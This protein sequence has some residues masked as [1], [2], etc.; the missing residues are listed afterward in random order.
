MTTKNLTILASDDDQDNLTALKAAVHDA[1]PGCILLSAQSGSKVLELARAEDPDV[2]LLNAAMS[3]MDGFAVCRGLKADE[4]LQAIPVLFMTALRTDRDSRIKA[5]EAGAEGFLFRPWEESELILQIRAMAKIK[6]ANQF[7]RVEKEE[8]A[9]LVAERTCA[10]E[11]ELAE[12]KRVGQALQQSEARFRGLAEALPDLL[13]TTDADGILTYVS[14]SIGSLLGW[15]PEEAVGRN[16]TEFLTPEEIPRIVAAFRAA[17][18]E[19]VPARNLMTTIKHKGG[20]LFSGEINGLS[21]L[22][23]RGTRGTVGVIRDVTERKRAEAKIQEQARLLDL[24]FEHSLDCIVLLDKD[25]NFIRVSEAYAKAC[26]R[27]VAEFQGLNHFELYPSS[28][29]DEFD[30][31]IRSRVVFSRSARPFTFP[32]HPEW[33]ATYWDLGMVPIRGVAGEVELILLTLKDVTERRRAE[34]DRLR[35][36]VAI[37]QAAEVVVVTDAQGT[38]QYV[39]PVFETVTGYTRAEA[40]GQNPRILKSGRQDA[41][42]YRELWD[43]L[44]AGRVWQGR[45]VNRR[46]DGSLYTEDVSISPVHDGAGRIV[47]YVAVKRDITEHL[48]DHE[49]KTRLEDHLR[50]AQKVEAIGRLAGGVAHDFNNLTAIVLG[51][52]EMLVGHL[53]H[54]DPARKWAE[55]I[56]EAGRRSAALTRQLLAFSRKQTLQPEVLDLNALVKNLEKMLGRLIGEDIELRFA[57]AADLGRVMA[58]PGQ[59]EQ[60]VTN[61][62]VNARDAMPGGGMLTIETTDVV[63][64]DTYALGHESVVPGN[65]VMLALTDTGSGLDKATMARLFEPFYT[66][67]EKGKGTGL[68][69]AMVYGIVKQSGGYIYAYSEPG[70]G[71]AFKI[72]LPRTDAQPDVK[73]AE[74]VGEPL[75]GSGEQILL[76]EDE[77]P[78]REL[79]QT[80]LSR[81]GYRVSAAG[82]G[83][84]AL[85]LVEEKGLAPDLVI[86]DVI[87]P[88]MSG[89]ALA[90][91]LRSRRPGLRVL[92]MSG[93]PDDAITRHGVLDPGTPFIQKPFAERDFGAKVQETLKWQATAVQPRRG[94]LMID[95]DEQYRELVRHFCAKQGYI[96]TGV[97]DT[98]GAIAAL[99]WQSFDVLLVDMNIPGTNGERVLWEI[100]AAGYAAPA[101]VLTGDVASADMEILRP[102]GVVRILEKSSRGDSLLRAIET[103]GEPSAN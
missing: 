97:S 19:G 26:N 45:L 12:S 99:A 35:L 46:K 55:Q 36:T 62:V 24:I 18:E 65:Y 6:R 78:L 16:F 103:A 98:A 44:T 22:T 37:E 60:V 30:D 101:I 88:G 74:A 25:Y 48:R 3:G 47:S 93:Y 1:L 91:R 84:E 87:M 42:F 29:K 89:A 59:I 71:T 40:I 21:I 20:W 92:F 70:K 69:L 76:V 95:D 7:C 102:L 100:R 83:Q 15:S 72:Y 52:G 75:R 81:L 64:D 5:L 66:T 96:F 34:T 68:G 11:Q 27:T 39:N 43:T 31:A 73:A 2:I 67:K 85:F 38:I 33:G 14:P 4:C 57:L 28:L 82:S 49:E 56:V 13:Y 77:T 79:C 32:D 17:V 9:A 41:A 8:L 54:E 51:Y 86:T 58:D 90:D 80:V 61:I 23:G 50:Q 10:L 94:I 63:L 53:D